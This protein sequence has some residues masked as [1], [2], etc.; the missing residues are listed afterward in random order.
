MAQQVYRRAGVSG[1][2]APIFD[3]MDYGGARLETSIGSRAPGRQRPRLGTVVCRGELHFQPLKVAIAQ[4]ISM[5]S[6][7]RHTRS[8]RITPDYAPAHRSRCGK[9]EAE[10]IG[11]TSNHFVREERSV[12]CG[13][14]T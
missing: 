8:R 3:R 11:Q 7:T 9:G 6:V 14:H 1:C 4:C 10:Q 5:L 12:T 13:F 2:W